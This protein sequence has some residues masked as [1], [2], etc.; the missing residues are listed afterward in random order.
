MDMHVAAAAV[1]ERGDGAAR[2]GVS[3]IAGRTRLADL[4]QRAPLRVLLPEAEPGE[5]LAA[6]VVTTSGGLADGDRLHLALEAGEDTAAQVTTQAAEKV[7]RA[8]GSVPARFDCEIAAMAGAWLEWL[9]QETILF[10]GARLARRTRAEIAPGARLFACEHVVF[11]RIARGESFR[12]GTLF[13]RW[14]LAR[15]GRPVWCD[16]L[17]LAPGADQARHAAWGFA[18]AEAVATT[19]FAADDAGAFLD[20]ARE[21]IAAALPEGAQAGATVVNGVLVTRWIGTAAAVQKGLS[22]FIAAFRG[23]AGGH[24]PAVPRGW[25]T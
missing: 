23:A 25:T 6:V 24:R 16:A 17:S 11:G 8:H 1:L 12:D 13:D 22:A 5:P 18:G 14:E 9:P 10:D 7:Y 3:L 2:I 15:E 4:Y 19:V 21:I 20:P